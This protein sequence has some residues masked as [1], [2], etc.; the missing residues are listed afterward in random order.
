MG[1][2]WNARK[3]SNS[4]PWLA[5]RL[6]RK[7]SANRPSDGYTPSTCP[8]SSIRK[9]RATST[10]VRYSVV[11]RTLAGRAT[12]PISRSNPP[13][14]A[15]S[16][17]TARSGSERMYLYRTG[18]LTLCSISGAPTC[19]E[20]RP[21]ARLLKNTLATDGHGCTRITPNSQT[22]V[23]LLCLSVCIRVHPWLEVFLQIA[24]RQLMPRYTRAS[25]R[26][27]G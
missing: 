4:I 2:A 8:T 16:D 26:G 13:E 14:S 22:L 10:M 7:F 17:R 6:R 23:L 19:Q 27:R 12:L 5:V 11:R 15:P 25:C 3:P 24:A 9:R 20:A 21:D 1:D 18:V